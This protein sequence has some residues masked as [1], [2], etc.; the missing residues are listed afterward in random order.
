M[1]YEL[2]VHLGKRATLR[3]D[4]VVSHVTAKHTLTIRCLD[5]KLYTFNMKSV[6]WFMATDPSYKAAEV[7]R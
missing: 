4:N 5:G 6:I 2:E 7:Q 3:F 1:I